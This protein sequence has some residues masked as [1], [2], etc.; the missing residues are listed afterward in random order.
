MFAPL[1]TASPIVIS[2]DERLGSYSNFAS[3]IYPVALKA[4][5]LENRTA[6]IALGM[7][8]QTPV[9]QSIASNLSDNAESDLL[10]L[11]VS[12]YTLVLSNSGLRLKTCWRTRPWAL[13][14]R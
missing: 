5:P 13:N 9:A 12:A 8:L 1:I 11:M 3:R 10:S 7:L 14:S 6:S 2:I 4:L